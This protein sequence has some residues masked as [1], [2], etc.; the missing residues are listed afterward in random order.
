MMQMHVCF[1]SDAASISTDVYL[2]Q[3][4]LIRQKD[5]FFNYLLRQLCFVRQS[6]KIQNK[7]SGLK[8]LKN[9]L[10]VTQQV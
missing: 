10:F 5:F 9:F 7:F 4:G 8:K 1:F 6:Y 3:L 2:R